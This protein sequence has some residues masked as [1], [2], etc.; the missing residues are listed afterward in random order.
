MKNYDEKTKDMAESVLPST[1]RKSVREERRR[2]HHA[3]RARQ[4]EAF[5][6][7]D[8]GGVEDYGP[9]FRE[10]RRLSATRWMVL[11]RRSADKIGPLTR[12]AVAVV[13]ADPDLRDAELAVQV[14]HF[15]RLFPDNLIGRHAVQHI[16]WALR[17]EA[18][19]PTWLDRRS[20]EAKE[21]HEHYRRVVGEVRRIIES[22][23]HGELNAALRQLYQQP[24][25]Q[26]GTLVTVPPAR[27]LLGAHDVGA[28]VHD[29]A[30]YG[31]VR[32]LIA[33]VAYSPVVD[34]RYGE[35]T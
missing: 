28:F 26:N 7:L 27:Y 29:V 30:P 22:G 15:A 14:A 13:T 16:E 2:I 19:R 11:D 8:V 10:G 1:A 17:Y 23:A 25:L 35:R 9:D 4:R 24:A 5:A 18:A 33:Q 20:A 12:W 34:R 6:R 21:T 31:A 3:Q 32:T